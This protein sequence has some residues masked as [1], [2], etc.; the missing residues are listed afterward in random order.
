MGEA[1]NSAHRDLGRNGG[2]EDSNL[3]G[4]TKIIMSKPQNSWYH[5]GGWWPSR[6][7]QPA[8]SGAAQAYQPAPDPPAPMPTTEP[9][10]SSLA[11]LLKWEAWDEFVNADKKRIVMEELQKREK[12]RDDLRELQAGSKRWA[13]R[14]KPAT[15]EKDEDDAYEKIGKEEKKSGWDLAWDGEDEV[16]SSATT[17]ERPKKVA[18]GEGR[19]SSEDHKAPTY[20]R[21]RTRISYHRRPPRRSRKI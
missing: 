9:P 7:E 19:G 13:A 10:T 15:K 12:G 2:L 6:E 11:A 5:Y 8:A 14:S 18:K 20:M 3:C 4:A 17:E 1:R 21:I 16:T